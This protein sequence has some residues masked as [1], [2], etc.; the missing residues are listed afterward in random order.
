MINGAEIAYEVTGDGEPVL[1]IH[2][3]FVADAMRP[4]AEQLDGYRVI[5]YHRRGYGESGGGVGPDVATHAADARALLEHLDAT[6]AHIIGHSYGGSAALALAASA[7]D[8]VRSLVLLEAATPGQIPSAEVIGGALGQ[9]VAPAMEG[10]LD[11]AVDRFLHMVLG[12]DWRKQTEEILS[13]AAVEQALADGD[14]AIVG[15]LGSL[16]AFAITGEDAARITCPALI[17][18]GG[19]TD[20]TVR[21]GLREMGIETPDV[22]VFGEMTA[23]QL[24]WLPQADVVTLA[25]INHSLQMQ[26]PSKVADAI[27]PFLAEQRQAAPA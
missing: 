16:A 20:E 25:G 9:V 7:P 5:R 21:T 18:L 24:T 4:L 2:G 27:E 19:S 26:D 13:A 10:K 22:D 3:A 8:A 11:E 17:V 23:V 1:L 14:D 12:R 15:D 6:P